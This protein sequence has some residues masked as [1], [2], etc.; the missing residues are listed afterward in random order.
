MSML[1]DVTLNELEKVEGKFQK[2]EKM[3]EAADLYF[4]FYFWEGCLQGAPTLYGNRNS[5]FKQQQQG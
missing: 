5:P 3:K 4:Y 1:G 2:E